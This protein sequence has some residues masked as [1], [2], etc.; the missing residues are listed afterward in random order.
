MTA[1]SL[2]LVLE[3]VQAHSYWRSQG[4]IVELAILNLVDSSYSQELQSQLQRLIGRSKSGTWLNQR[5]GIFIINAD[6]MGEQ[7]ANLLHSVAR[8]ILDG[9]KGSSAEQLPPMSNTQ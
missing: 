9:N 4:M 6:Q 5:G 7:N 1:Q 3:A 8:V 2:P